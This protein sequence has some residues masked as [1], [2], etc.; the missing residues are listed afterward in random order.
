MKSSH[1]PDADAREKPRPQADAHARS[2]R[3]NQKKIE[4]RSRTEFEN[5]EERVWNAYGG[6]LARASAGI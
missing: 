1:T 2:Q 3:K 6:K 4:G 5:F